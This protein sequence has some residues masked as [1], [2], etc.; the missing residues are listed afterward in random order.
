METLFCGSHKFELLPKE[1]SNGNKLIN[2]KRTN[3]KKLQT[4]QKKELIFSVLFS[5]TKSPLSRG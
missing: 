2:V 3:L 5:K 1:N 4:L